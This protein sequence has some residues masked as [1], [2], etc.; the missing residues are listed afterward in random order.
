M[1]L[2]VKKFPFIEQLDS[3]D[4]GFACIRIISK[5]YSVNVSVDNKAFTESH[6]TKQG[7]SFPELAKAS[8]NIG[9][10]NLFVELN[11]EE[12]QENVTLP[13]IF[14]W[15]Q[16]HFIVVYNITNDKVYVSDPAIGKIIYDKEY[17]LENWKGNSEKG[18]ILLLQPTKKLY[19][20]NIIEK[21]KR[22]KNF[23]HVLKYLMDYKK[24][25]YLL[26]V[27]LFISSII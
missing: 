13:A 23:I 15:N 18:I 16:N 11:F 4:C 27:L 5:Y 1:K 12:T 25:L 14:F 10:E 7:L 22:R 2:K 9:Y 20:N 3:S 19:E 17:F 6:L 8:S 24:Q 21:K 26:A